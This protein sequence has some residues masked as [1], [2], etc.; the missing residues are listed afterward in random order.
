MPRPVQNT[1]VEEVSTSAASL[2]LV[3]QPSGGDPRFLDQSSVLEIRSIRLD[4]QTQHRLALDKT[5]VRQYSLLMEEGVALP[6][7]TV[8]YDGDN[9]WLTD[10]FHRIAAAEQVG[11]PYVRAQVRLGSLSDA[12]W[13]SYAANSDHGLR[14]KPVE[15]RAVVRLALQHPRAATLSNV[16]LARHVNLPEATLRRW[17]KQLSSS[18]DEDKVRMVSRGGSTYALRTANIGK[19]RPQRRQLAS[20]KQLRKELTAMKGMASTDT[21]RIIVIF[22]SWAQGTAT[23]EEC[24]R[25][26]DKVVKEWSISREVNHHSM[27]TP[28]F[29]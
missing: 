18:P 28:P 26:I 25:A 20:L 13:D 15:I 3:T 7:V 2:R 14:R 22:S 19:T 5:V 1:A 11:S 21:R 23:S 6:P 29:R 27:R 4:G 24:L 10:G 17:R 8:W 16:E 12:R 9:Y